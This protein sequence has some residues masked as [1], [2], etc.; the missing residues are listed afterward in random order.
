MELKDVID[1]CV[2]EQIDELLKDEE[3]EANRVRRN[4]LASE[5]HELV[6]LHTGNMVRNYCPKCHK[7]TMGEQTEWWTK[8]YPTARWSDRTRHQIF[9]CGICKEKTE[10]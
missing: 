8:I 9:I 1:Q 3:K 4:G 2:K 6:N 10:M 5:G 7:Y